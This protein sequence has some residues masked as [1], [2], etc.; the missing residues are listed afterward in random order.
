[1]ALKE[2][3]ISELNVRIRQMEEKINADRLAKLHME[4]ALNEYDVKHIQIIKNFNKL[5]LGKLMIFKCNWPN[6]L[7]IYPNF[8][9]LENERSKQDLLES[10][11]R[12]EELEMVILLEY[13]NTDRLKGKIDHLVKS[14]LIASK[15]FLSKNFELFQLYLLV[16]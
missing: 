13:S 10:K 5:T 9:F 12:N 11:K 3:T 6:N 8:N 7:L 2:N 15:A 14:V 4:E 16:T 1:M